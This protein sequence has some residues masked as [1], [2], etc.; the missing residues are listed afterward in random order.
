MIPRPFPN[1]YP[2]YSQYPERIY[3]EETIYPE[4]MTEDSSSG[5]SNIAMVKMLTDQYEKDNTIDKKIINTVSQILLKNKK[6]EDTDLVELF[7]K[8]YLRHG[9]DK[10]QT[11]RFLQ[12]NNLSPFQRWNLLG[13]R[14]RGSQLQD[15][16]SSFSAM[17]PSKSLHRQYGS[18]RARV[19]SN[20]TR[21][22]SNIRTRPI[23]SKTRSRKRTTK[24]NK[25]KN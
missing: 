21:T 9:S 25:R 24:T 6:L 3:A 18:N 1:Q 11:V 15:T 19:K 20:K 2:Q 4:F 17:T 5:L 12:N 23:R 16:Y 13:G 14:D 22:K 7:W 10:A 8:L